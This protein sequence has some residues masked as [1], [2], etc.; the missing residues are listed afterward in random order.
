M[1]LD[2]MVDCRDYH[3]TVSP[4]IIIASTG[5]I[6]NVGFRRARHQVTTTPSSSVIL[7]ADEQKSATRRHAQYYYYYYDKSRREGSRVSNV[8]MVGKQNFLFPSV[9][10]S[11]SRLLWVRAATPAGTRHASFPSG[12]LR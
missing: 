11:S 7:R 6:G 12:T 2:G 1:D 5:I 3:S 8:G 9:A 4:S 10:F